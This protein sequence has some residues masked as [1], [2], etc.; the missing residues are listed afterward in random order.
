MTNFGTILLVV[1]IYVA[2]LSCY[3][4]ATKKRI[5]V[6]IYKNAFVLYG[7][8]FLLAEFLPESRESAIRLV[9][10]AFSEEFPV[11]TILLEILMTA[12][13]FLPLGFLSAMSSALRGEAKPFLKAVLLGALLSL[14]A[15]LIQLAPLGKTFATDHILMNLI[16][17]AVGYAVFAALSGTER[18]RDVL[19]EILYPEQ[20]QN[21][22]N[23]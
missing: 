8:V 2:T 9:P 6:R 5:A 10:F 15:E 17:T 20:S 3:L 12:V 21:Q 11:G 19:R 18:M 7:I 22:S 23:Q 13:L 4:V 1:V 16:G 14:V